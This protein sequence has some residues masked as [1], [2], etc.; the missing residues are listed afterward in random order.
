M[1]HYLVHVDACS[2]NKSVCPKKNNTEPL[3]KIEKSTKLPLKCNNYF[4]HQKI[5][6]NK[7]VQ[8]SSLAACQEV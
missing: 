1:Q 8:L 5:I 4:C 6:F 2:E 7:P 3:E